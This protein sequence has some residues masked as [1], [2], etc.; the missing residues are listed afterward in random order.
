M[1]DNLDQYD[2]GASKYLKSLKLNSMPL[3]SWDFYGNYFQN[4]SGLLSDQKQLQS[5]ARDN[6]WVHEL[7]LQKELEK[8]TV[9]IV[10]NPEIKIVFS[11]QNMIKMN[12]Y[13]SEEVLGKS[14]K[15]FQG[16]KSSAETNIEIRKAIELRQPFDKI[17]VNYRKNGIAYDCHVKGFPVFNTK[18]KLIHFIA[19]EKVA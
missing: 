10:T 2:K 15:M 11:S 8:D 18:G 12:G 14:P 7:D 6:H 3:H 9:I 16:E 4:L 17:I 1:T 19:L 5:L 13:Q